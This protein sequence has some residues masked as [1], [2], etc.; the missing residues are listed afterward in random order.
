MKF[1]RLRLLAGVLAL[2]CSVA[3]A[4][5]SRVPVRM[6]SGFPPGGNVDILARVFAEKL[7]EA[8]GRPVVVEAR[9]GAGG[10]IGLE[11]LKASAP[12]GNTLGL[13]PDASLLV[14][15]LTMKSPPYDPLNDFAAVAQTGAQ[16]Y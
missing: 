12:D 7:S 13:T 6:I 2:A 11:A 10:Q 8:I 16:D 15:P 4:Q 9:V 3:S 5:T 1:S 14:R